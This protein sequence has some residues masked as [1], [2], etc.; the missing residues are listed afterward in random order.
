MNELLYIQYTTLQ[1][2][3]EYYLKVFS[4]K[5]FV[6]GFGV[7]KYCWRQEQRTRLSSPKLENVLSFLVLKDEHWRSAFD[8]KLAGL[9]SELELGLG[10]VVRQSGAQPSAKK[11]RTEEDVLGMHIHFSSKKY[12][13][14]GHSAYRMILEVI[15]LFGEEFYNCYSLRKS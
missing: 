12:T 11:A 1:Y 5:E 6:K 7:P 3:V 10:S 8:P 2:I 14:Q 15:V 9:L 4:Q 13:G